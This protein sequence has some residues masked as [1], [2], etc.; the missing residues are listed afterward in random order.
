MESLQYHHKYPP[1]N[2]RDSKLS[3]NSKRNKQPF[4]FFHFICYKHLFHLLLMDLEINFFLKFI[5]HHQSPAQIK[6]RRYLNYGQDT[7]R[8][9]SENPSL[10]SIPFVAVQK[11]RPT[12]FRMQ[13][14]HSTWVG[15]SCNL[16]HSRDSPAAGD[17]F[18]TRCS[19]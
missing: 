17:Y 12:R 15:S 19:F 2:S 9:S 16:I 10:V 5:I 8:G 6:A 3:L 1:C 14:G 11:R 13:H 18:S 7:S 4:L